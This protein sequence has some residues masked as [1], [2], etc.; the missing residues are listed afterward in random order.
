M[1]VWMDSLRAALAALGSHRLRTLLTMLSVSLG[2]GAISLM[3]SLSSS[4]IATISRG[5]E[6]SG[7]KH[8]I[9][10]ANKMPSDFKPYYWDRGLPTAD[11]DALRERLP[12][13][14]RV[15]FL[16]PPM[17][18]EPVLINGRL[19]DADI[20]PGSS[21]F[22]FMAQQ[23]SYGRRIPDDASGDLSRVTVIARPLAEAVF[24]DAKKAIGETVVFYRHRY[25]IVG[26]AED[27]VKTSFNME[28]IDKQHALYVSSQAMI[29]N[30]GLVDDGFIVLKSDGTYSHD[31]IIQ[32]AN[33]ILMRRH[34]DADDVL[35]NDFAVFIERF[36]LIFL[37]LQVLTGL[38]AALSLMIA[39]AGIMNVLLASVRDRVTEI[40]IRRALGASAGDIERHF[41]AE[42]IVLGSFGGLLG[43]AG[44]LIAAYVG[45]QVIARFV[46]GWSAKLSFS[47]A[48][49]AVIVATAA[50]LIFGL[51]PARQAA[52]L[53]VVACLRGE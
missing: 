26:V 46:D 48:L 11:A 32:L 5:V 6:E 50:A 4:G 10:V 22:D 44:G 37:A 53:D 9:F 21:W 51:R 38:I 30:E 29:K 24:G 16:L 2:A 8:L 13:C 39:G 43:S 18:H 15:A 14:E 52:R 45:S 23:V 7:G 12:G 27:S 40:G 19:V 47:A 20:V 31:H 33:K 35:F 42:A 49:I 41:L 1:S 17:R 25:T 36:N 28:D 34:H 3:V